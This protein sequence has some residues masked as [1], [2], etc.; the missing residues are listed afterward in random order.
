MSLAPTLAVAAFVANQTYGKLPEPVK[1]HLFALSLD[2][3]RVASIGQRQEWSTWA[4]TLTHKMRGSGNSQIMFSNTRCDPEWA[5]FVNSAY[6]GSMDIDDVHVGGMIHPGCVVFSAALAIAQDRNLA[7]ADLLAAVSAGY[8]VMIRMSLCLQPTHYSRGF[9]STSTCGTFGAAAA[10]AHLL[11]RGADRTQRIAETLGIAASSAGGLLQFYHSGSTVKRIHSANATKAG[12]HAALL[13]E[14]GFSGPTDVLEGQDGF[15]RAYADGVN[16]DVLTGDIGKRYCLLDVAV[17]EHSCASRILSSIEATV[18]LVRR[19]SLKPSDIAS[20]RVGV[21]RLVQGKLTATQPRDV[22]ASQMSI[23]FSIALA[24][25]RTDLTATTG[26]FLGVEDYSTG[27]ANAAVMDFSGRVQCDIDS[28]VEA[29]SSPE[30]VA[31]KVTLRL[32]SGKEVTEFVQFPKGSK[33][34]P[35]TEQEHI[36]RTYSELGRRYSPAQCAAFVD[37]LRNLPML[38]NVADMPRALGHV[39][40]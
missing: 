19:H 21:T 15:A 18:S 1:T 6:S 17:K 38:A 14:A 8:E 25:A 28:E 31:S 9:Q 27:F 7:G 23:P 32:I 29:A 30:S 12:V 11:F 40:T 34:R 36:D 24:T 5:A 10:A 26:P 35:F 3:F 13:V 33:S 2:H 20:C 37:C 39:A 22:L 16:F 4:E